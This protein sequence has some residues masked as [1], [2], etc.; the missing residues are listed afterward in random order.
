MVKDMPVPPTQLMTL[1]SKIDAYSIAIAALRRIVGPDY[2]MPT[3][4]GVEV[5]PEIYA[6][7]ALS[8]AYLTSRETFEVTRA[9]YEHDF[10]TWH[11]DTL[12]RADAL[13]RGDPIPGVVAQVMPTAATPEWVEPATPDS[14]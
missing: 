2:N 11:T 4:P 5:E 10:M 8:E 6:F 7:R 14:E 13:F 9:Q 1:A 3:P 12:A